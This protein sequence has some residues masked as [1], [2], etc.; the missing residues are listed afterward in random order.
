MSKETPLQQMLLKL[1][2]IF[3]DAVTETQRKDNGNLHYEYAL[4]EE[5]VNQLREEGLDVADDQNRYELQFPGKLAAKA[6]AFVPS[7]KTL[8]ADKEQSKNFDNTGN[9]FIEGDNLDVLRMLQNSYRSNCLLYT[10]PSPRDRTR[11]R[12]PSSA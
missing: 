5:F 6:Q 9:V 2:A 10:S 4:K 3:P 12:M 11:S 7:Y 8:V 1:K